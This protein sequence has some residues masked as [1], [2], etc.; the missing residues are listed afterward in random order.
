MSIWCLFALVTECS[1][2]VSSQVTIGFISGDRDGVFFVMENATE[3]ERILCVVANF[4]SGTES[5]KTVDTA[6]MSRGAVGKLI[7]I[8]LA[9]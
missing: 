3:D 1:L 7:D 9:I 4:S 6:Y 2:L 8:E 5:A